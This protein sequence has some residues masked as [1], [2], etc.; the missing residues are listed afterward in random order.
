MPVCFKVEIAGYAAKVCLLASTIGAK[1]RDVSLD[2]DRQRST[3]SLRRKATYSPRVAQQLG[4]LGKKTCAYRSDS[5]WYINLGEKLG[6]GTPDYPGIEKPMTY[7]TREVPATK[8][9]FPR[10]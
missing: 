10:A 4:S 8:I 1:S 6:H 3:P 9:L 2:P 7:M 5:T